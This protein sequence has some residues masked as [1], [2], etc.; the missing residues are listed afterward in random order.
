MSKDETLKA[1]MVNMD[2]FI[3]AGHSAG[4]VSTQKIDTLP[5]IECRDSNREMSGFWRNHQG[6][7]V[8]GASM[9]MPETGWTLLVE[10]AMRKK[11]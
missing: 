1:Y 11:P 10:A 2:G 6:I 4:A 5:V 8:I 7:E 9:C 3:I